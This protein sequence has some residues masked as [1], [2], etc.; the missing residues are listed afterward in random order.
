[1]KSMIQP[2]PQRPGRRKTMGDKTRG[3]Y[4]KFIVRRTDGKDAPGQKH[5][6]CYYFVLDPSHDPMAIP[7]IRA[8]ATA[9][10]E[11]GYG[12]LADDLEAWL[13]TALA[14]SSGKEQIVFERSGGRVTYVPETSNTGKETP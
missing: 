8:Y 7:A 12:L 5:D 6:G 9:A 4:N 13:S 11:A 1:M 14:P 10:R 3:L 2:P